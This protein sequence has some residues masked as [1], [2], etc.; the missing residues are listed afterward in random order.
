MVYIY[1]NGNPLKKANRMEGQSWLTMRRRGR[2]ELKKNEGR[3]GRKCLWVLHSVNVC[4]SAAPPLRCWWWW[5]L[6]HHRFSQGNRR[7]TMAPQ[8]KSFWLTSGIIQELIQVLCVSFC[9]ENTV[10]P[11]GQVLASYKWECGAALLP[12]NLG[13]AVNQ[14]Q[15]LMGRRSKG[16]KEKVQLWLWKD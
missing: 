13:E 5:Q 15:G 14:K 8:S 10:V 4:S 1:V 3:K 2:R 9:C 12:L 11:H 6:M 16:A 7:M